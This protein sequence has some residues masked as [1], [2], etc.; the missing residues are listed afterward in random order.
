MKNW[1]KWAAAGAAL[2]LV[3]VVAT[4]LFRATLPKPV[5]DFSG[6]DLRGKPW[7]LAEH[8]GKGPIIVNF[9]ATWCG[10][11]REEVPL[12]AQAQRDFADR[13]TKL[14][15]LSAEPAETLKAAGLAKAP[16]PVLPN[17]EDAFKAYKVGPIPR[18]LFFDEKGALRHDV[19]GFDQ[20]EI[21][22]I[23]RYLEKLPASRS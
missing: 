21:E 2:L 5:S 3:G 1:G 19:E 6:V 11:C 18:T 13:G 14:V 4:E 20:R 9:F 7:S 10:P 12:L 23:R 16:F 17:S 22:K 15:L 8:R